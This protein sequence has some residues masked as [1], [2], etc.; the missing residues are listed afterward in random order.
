VPIQAIQQINI[1]YL[2]NIDSTFVVPANQKAFLIWSNVQ[3]VVDMFVGAFVID[4][5]IYTQYTIPVYDFSFSDFKKLVTNSNSRET[6]IDYDAK[7][8]KNNVLIRWSRPRQ[9]GTNIN[10]INRFYDNNYI[11][12]NNEYGAVKRLDANGQK[13]HVFQERKC[14]VTGVYNKY[15]K[16]SGG[17]TQLIVTDTILTSNNIEYYIANNGIGNQSMSLV[18]NGFQYYFPDPVKGQYCRLSQ[19]GVTVISEIFKVQSW[20]GNNIPNYQSNYPYQYGGNAKILGTWNVKKD[21]TSELVIVCQNGTGLTGSALIFNE[22]KNQFTSFRDWSNID[23]IDCVNNQL[24]AFQ[25]GELYI[26]DNINNYNNFFGTNYPSEITIVVNDG[27]N[28]KKEPLAVAYHGS[29]VWSCPNIGDVKTSFNQNSM[30]PS[31]TFITRESMFYAAIQR[32]DDGTGN[33]YDSLI[34]LKGV[35]ISVKFSINS[36]NFEYINGIQVLIKNSPKN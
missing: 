35:W 21:K 12:A 30:I 18:R 6:A 13:L 19:D 11:E 7:Q 34:Y 9:T 32:A 20:A 15:I 2:I 22:E 36:N 23:A 31:A 29:N 10:E 16:N 5:Y 25:N 24:I 3:Q 27:Q 1:G 17:D 28:V 14:G 4:T 26:F 8:T 33:T